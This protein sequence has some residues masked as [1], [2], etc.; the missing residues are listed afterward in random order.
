MACHLEVGDDAARPSSIK[1]FP[2]LTALRFGSG[3]EHFFCAHFLYAKGY[4]PLLG[5][6]PSGFCYLVTPLKYAEIVSHLT[7][8]KKENI[9]FKR[10]LIC[11]GKQC[12]FNIEHIKSS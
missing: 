8:S 9:D 11:R 2:Q 12:I 3:S 6:F 10:H 7:R 5:N 4:F 1:R